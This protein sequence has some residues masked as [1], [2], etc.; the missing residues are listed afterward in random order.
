[1][2][3]TDNTKFWQ[4]YEI[5]EPCTYWDLK[6]K[7]E[8]KLFDRSIKVEHM[9]ILWFSKSTTMFKLKRYALMCMWTKINVLEYLYQHNSQLAEIRNN[10]NFHGQ[11]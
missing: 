1:M 7:M 6:Y 4:G 2:K 10:L 5:T 3:N 11:K 9:H 8:Q